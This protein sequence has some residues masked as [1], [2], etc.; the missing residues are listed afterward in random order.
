[1]ETLQEI[2]LPAFKFRSKDSG[3]SLQ[4][5][6]TAFI[7]KEASEIYRRVQSLDL[8]LH[9]SGITQFDMTV[10]IGGSHMNSISPDSGV[11]ETIAYDVCESEVRCLSSEAVGL[12]DPVLGLE[13]AGPPNPIS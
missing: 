1:M 10:I 5:T 13:K 7:D 6:S 11:L 3:W 2:A 9:S 4:V 12:T 8:L